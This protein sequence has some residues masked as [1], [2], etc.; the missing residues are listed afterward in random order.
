MNKIKKKDSSGNPVNFKDSVIT[1]FKEVRSEWGKI[2]WP[3]RS[4]VIRETL[5]VIFVVF[6]FTIF[7]YFLDIIFKWLLG[8]IPVR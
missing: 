7:I 5:V 8:L 1:Y 3:E 6:F 4:Q 2:T